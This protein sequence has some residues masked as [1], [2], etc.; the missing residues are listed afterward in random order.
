LPEPGN[1]C[2]SKPEFPQE[3]YRQIRTA[4]VVRDMFHYVEHMWRQIMEQQ[5]PGPGITRSAMDMPVM[6][7]GATSGRHRVSRR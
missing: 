6:H 3:S 2:Q 4:R 7:L 5:S 1:I